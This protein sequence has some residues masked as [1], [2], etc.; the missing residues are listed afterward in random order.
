MCEQSKGN[1]RDGRWDI[2]AWRGSDVLFIESK[3]RSNDHIRPA[4]A[5]WLEHTLENGVPLSSFLIAE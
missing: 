5:S 1:C 2:F 3:Q 4:Q